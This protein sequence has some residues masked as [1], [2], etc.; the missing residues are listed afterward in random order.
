MRLRHFQPLFMQAL[1]V[2]GYGI[3]HVLLR[4]F[5]RGTGGDTAWQ[6]GRKGGEAGLR[7][8][9][10]NQVSHFRPACLSTLFNVPGA[11]SSFSLP[12]M[13]TKPGFSRCLNW[14]WLPLVLTMNHPSSSIILITA[15]TFIHEIVARTSLIDKQERTLLHISAPVPIKHRA[16]DRKGFDITDENSVHQ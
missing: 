12:A 10:D 14:R 5:P 4:F 1:Q 3:P 11:R 16:E 6:I 7:F 8:L 2:E 9:D 13:V 15:L